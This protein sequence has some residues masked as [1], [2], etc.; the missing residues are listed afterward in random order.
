MPAMTIA[1]L[2]LQLS[3]NPPTH[4][5][6]GVFVDDDPP[7]PGK[8]Y[9]LPGYGAPAPQPP[10]SADVID[11]A[12][13]TITNV[14][15]GQDGRELGGAKIVTVDSQ[16]AQTKVSVAQAGRLLHPCSLAASAEL[17]PRDPNG[18]RY[19]GFLLKCASPIRGS[20]TVVAAVGLDGQ[21]PRTVF[22]NIGPR[23]E[24]EMR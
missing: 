7:T 6:P 11:A 16:A 1:A 22:I 19:F 5:A 21:T 17:G 20:D 13:A 4:V 14:L 24:I 3:A 10:S 12:K 23:L 8:V 9:I 18:R 2:L 15:R